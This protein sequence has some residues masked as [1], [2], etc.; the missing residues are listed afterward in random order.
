M[1]DVGAG[2]GV[3]TAHLL[4]AGARV[5]AIELHDRRVA[6]LRERFA[7][8]D[9]TV[10]RADASDLRLPARPFKVVANPPFGVTT[11][12][13]RRLT[14]RSSRLERAESRP[15]DVGG[16]ALGG[17]TRCRTAERLRVL[18]RPAGPG[19]RVPAAASPGRPRPGRESASAV[20]L[21][22]ARVRGTNP[23]TPD[24]V[25]PSD[26]PTATKAPRSRHAFP[27][28]GLGPARTTGAP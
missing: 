15:P 6:Q 9:V 5:I 7:D 25:P 2:G 10:V 11:A 3:L 4:R 14:A 13:L 22:Q 24:L 1:L 19:P 16:G 27:R 12:L 26:A 8:C 20:A 18:A 21:N 28:A 17:R 23:R